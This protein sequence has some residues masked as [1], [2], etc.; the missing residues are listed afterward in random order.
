MIKYTVRKAT[1][2]DLQL[3][4]DIRKNALG[5]YVRQTWGWNEDWQWAYHLKDFDPKILSIIECDDIPVATVEEVI[6][7]DMVLVSGIYI[8]NDYQSMGIGKDLMDD[9]ILRAKKIN[10]P[11]KLQVL[12]VNQRA[13]EFYL[14]LGFEVYDETE[15]HYRMVL[16]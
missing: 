15:T 4:Y 1:E 6:L 8:I 2:D 5:D 7:D 13:K 3:A 10:K 16:N 11:V 12:K 14:R 9:I